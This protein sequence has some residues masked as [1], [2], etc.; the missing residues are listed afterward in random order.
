MILFEEQTNHNETE[1]H[2]IL[3]TFA[4]IGMFNI[5][6]MKENSENGTGYEAMIYYPFSVQTSSFRYLTHP[7]QFS[8]YFPS[9][10]TNLYGYKFNIYNATKA[11]KSHPARLHGTGGK[12]LEVIL[13]R[14]NATYDII[15]FQGCLSNLGKHKY[16]N[17]TLFSMHMPAFEDLKALEFE[18]VWLQER[19]EIGVLITSKA[20]NADLIILNFIRFIFVYYLVV[21]VFMILYNL[22]LEKRGTLIFSYNLIIPLSSQQGAGIHIKNMNLRTRLFLYCILL[23]SFHLSLIGVAEITEKYMM[24]Y[25]PDRSIQTLANVYEQKIPI[26]SL[27]YCIFNFPQYSL[28]HLPQYSTINQSIWLQPEPKETDQKTAYLV[29]MEYQKI[30]LSSANNVNGHNRAKYYLLKELYMSVPSVYLMPK[31]SPVRDVIAEVITWSTEGGLPTHWTVKELIKRKE[32]GFRI[33]PGDGDLQ[34]RPGLHLDSFRY[35]FVLILLQ[36]I[37]AIV[38]FLGEVLWSRYIKRHKENKEKERRKKLLERILKKYQYL[39]ED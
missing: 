19:Y 37:A 6:I 22:I 16:R 15:Q 27:P 29:E 3:T 34:S 33:W 13:K 39:L 31:H 23:N 18:P 17:D 20:V 25:N 9:K 7:R 38:V 32:F 30:I 10:V 8:D 12:E 14:I 11:P 36:Y 26:K 4:R 21:I 35:V 24:V 1:W 5:C 28:K 2:H